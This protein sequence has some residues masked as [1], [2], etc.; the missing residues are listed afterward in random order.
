MSSFS[1]FLSGVMISFFTLL[2]I[3]LSAVLPGLRDIRTV[4]LISSMI[5]DYELLAALIRFIIRIVE[6]EGGGGSGIVDCEGNSG[7]PV[8]AFR[9]VRIYLLDG[10]E[11]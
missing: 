4:A 3:L 7:P 11:A 2:K 8:T 5:N 6:K 1:W 10:D 9:V